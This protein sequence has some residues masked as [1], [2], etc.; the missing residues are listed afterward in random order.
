MES[1]TIFV[2]LLLGLLLSFSS[3]IVTVSLFQ[4][5]KNFFSSVFFF[6]DNVDE[7]GCRTTQLKKNSQVLDIVAEEFHVSC[8][9]LCFYTHSPDL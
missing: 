9:R 8:F 4:G 5:F 1:L 3:N 2:V 6:S 7:I